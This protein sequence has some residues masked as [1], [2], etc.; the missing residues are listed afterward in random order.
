MDHN[1]THGLS[2]LLPMTPQRYKE[3]TPL[4]HSL[5]YVHP[6][7]VLIG[8]VELGE[9]TSIWPMSVLRGDN[10]AIRIGARTNIQ[11]GSIGHATLGVSKT[12]IGL[13]CTVG[14]RVTLHG[15][16]VGNHCLVGMGSTLLD[17]V[18]VGD[19]CFIAAGSLLTPNKIFEPRSFVMGSPARRVREVKASELEAIAHGWKTY[20]ELARTYR[21]GPTT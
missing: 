4:V 15:C 12:T 3:H 7:V 11:D 17:G 1:L 10:G 9:E 5:A 20:V 21:G 14:H 16:T 8:E 18:V 19:D 6:S 2:T 13:E